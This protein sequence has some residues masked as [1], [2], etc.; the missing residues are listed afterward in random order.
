MNGRAAEQTVVAL[1]VAYLV[2]LAWAMANLSYDMWGAFVVVPVLL[3]IGVPLLRRM[4]RGSQAQL[5]SVMV[6][7][8]VAKLAGGA[9]RY[10][11]S[12]E[13]YGGQTDAQRYHKYAAKAASDVWAGRASWT[14]VVPY[15][16]GTAF[17]ERFTGLVYTVSGSSLLGGFFVFA[18][19][20]YWGVAL[21]VKAAVVAIPGLA[22][23]R[24]ALIV[25]LAPSVL[26]W[27]SSIGKEA[28]L[29]L[30]L[31]FGTF[32][33]ARLLS[34]RGFVVSAAIT[35]AGLGGAAFVRPHIAGLW[36]AGMMPALVVALLRGR[37]RSTRRSGSRAGDIFVVG[38]LIAVAL[39]GLSVMAKT[40]VDYLNPS[41]DE[42]SATSIGDILAE[43]T[44]RTSKGS[45]STFVPPAVASPTDWPYAS[46]RTLTRPLIIEAQGFSQLL[47]AAEIMALLGL[48]AV[49]W[50]RVVNLPRLMM[51]NPFVAFA[52][53]TLFLAGLAYS[54]F[55][56][57]GVL[58]RQKS[59]IFP[60][61]L[62]ITCLPEHVA[63]I[64]RVPRDQ[65]SS[66]SP[67]ESA[68]LASGGMPARL[69]ARQVSTGPPPGNGIDRD[70]IWA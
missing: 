30:T 67:R 51:T 55:A 61:M 10:W 12:F 14:S 57:L 27:P 22:R 11:V 34:R 9:A 56:N 13:A 7:G 70:D 23:R 41:T 28:Y 35:V 5:F 15:G 68:Q 53:T 52:M 1:A 25:V 64:R 47:V 33:I 43:T 58:T 50:R 65:N 24:Y 8:L 54:S 2:G 40:T 16:T 26:F 60:F 46:L 18:W 62:L 21:F 32:G 38:L 20:A 44:R 31:G 29:F 42:V 39:A 66:T 48:C 63:I 19:I 45:G 3:I 59:L 4:F 49:S 6:V 69:T 17:L 37:G 36:I